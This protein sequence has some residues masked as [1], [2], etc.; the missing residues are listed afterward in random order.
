MFLCPKYWPYSIEVLF[1]ISKEVKNWRE[2]PCG[3]TRIYI[4]RIQREKERDL[5]Q[6]Y[7]KTPYTNRK[8]ENQRTTHKRHQKLRLHND[9]LGRSVSTN[10]TRE[11]GACDD[12]KSR[13]QKARNDFLALN[14]VWKSIE[15]F[16]SSSHYFRS[17]YAFLH[18]AIIPTWNFLW[19]SPIKYL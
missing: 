12:I 15:I 19:N 16:W 7:D 6:S 8:F 11:G 13:L 18:K 3:C 14:Q 10:V 17:D 2:R 9:C 5:T 1:Y 4:P